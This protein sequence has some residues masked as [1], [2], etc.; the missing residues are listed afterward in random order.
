MYNMH[1]FEDK[2]RWGLLRCTNTK[3]HSNVQVYPHKSPRANP[4]QDHAC[5]ANL[6]FYNFF[7]SFN[8][9]QLFIDIWKGK[10]FKDTNSQV[11]EIK[12]KQYEQREVQQAALQLKI[13]KKNN[14]GQGPQQDQKEIKV[15]QL[16]IL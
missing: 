8:K 4:I 15:P 10:K 6:V 5:M 7:S 11:S 2:E 3:D 1:Q 13:R 16:S 12:K 14:I 9:K